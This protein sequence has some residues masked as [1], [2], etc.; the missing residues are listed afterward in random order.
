MLQNQ[1]IGLVIDKAQLGTASPDVIAIRSPVAVK[2]VPV[3]VK[4]SLA[5]SFQGS[6]CLHLFFKKCLCD[7]LCKQSVTLLIQVSPV[8]C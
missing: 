7:D 1:A 5:E 8:N 2:P 3:F 6:F 4:N